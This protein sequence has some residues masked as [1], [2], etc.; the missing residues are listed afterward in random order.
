[1]K[2]WTIILF[3]LGLGAFINGECVINDR[4]VTH[5]STITTFVIGF[6]WV[7]GGVILM[8]P[9]ILN[10]KKGDKDGNSD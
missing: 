9:F 6:C 4:T 8:T 7:I 5:N 3:S 2:I 10:N 1:M